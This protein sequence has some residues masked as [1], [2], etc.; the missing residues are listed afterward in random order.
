M[1][2]E[3]IAEVT[4][5]PA[6]GDSLFATASATAAIAIWLLPEANIAALP[7]IRLL[8]SGRLSASAT[9]SVPAETT[10]EPPKVSAPE[11]VAVPAPLLLRPPVPMMDPLTVA[12]AP[13]RPRR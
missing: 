7:T 9:A 5:E 1:A 10:V 11:S 6:A 2:E 4:E 12:V 3:C 8:P 13:R